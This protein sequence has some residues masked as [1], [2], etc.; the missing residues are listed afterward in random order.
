MAMLGRPAGAAASQLGAR[1][2]ILQKIG[3][4]LNNKVVKPTLSFGQELTTNTQ[5]ALDAGSKVLDTLGKVPVIGGL[6][7][8]PARAALG[9]AQALQN[10]ASDA[11]NLGM[12]AEAGAPRG[13]LLQSG[14]NLGVDIARAGGS[15][16]VGILAPRIFG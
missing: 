12:Q 15:A 14:R 8:A 4:F 7:T 11:V 2:S 6:V 3:S 9:N 16:A 13:Q 5:G 1:P 10:V